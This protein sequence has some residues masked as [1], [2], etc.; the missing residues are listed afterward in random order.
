MSTGASLS[1]GVGAVLGGPELYE[2]PTDR[3]INEFLKIFNP[4]QPP[5]PAHTHAM[6]SVV[7]IVPGSLHQSE[8]VGLL[9]GRPSEDQRR[10]EF[11]L[12]L[13]ATFRRARRT[14]AGKI[15]E[16]PPPDWESRLKE[17]LLH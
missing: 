8:H 14:D 16:P 9:A 13:P 3:V 4:P 5:G 11:Y 7:V 1:I 15:C 12:F 6:V 17:Y 10:L 2:G